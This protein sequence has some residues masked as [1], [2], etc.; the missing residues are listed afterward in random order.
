MRVREKG[1]GVPVRSLRAPS[2]VPSQPQTAANVRGFSLTSLGFA[3]E[4]DWLLEQR[5]FELSVPP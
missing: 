2:H 1:E 4:T 5:R 3:V